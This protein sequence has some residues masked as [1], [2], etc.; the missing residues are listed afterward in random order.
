MNPITFPGLGELT[1]ETMTNNIFSNFRLAREIQR[2]FS[3]SVARKDV[4]T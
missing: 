2:S 4:V 3:G 1:I